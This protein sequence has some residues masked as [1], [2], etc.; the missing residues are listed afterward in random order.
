MLVLKLSKF[1]Y[2]CRVFNTYMERNLSNFRKSRMLLEKRFY[3][4]GILTSIRVPRLTKI[5]TLYRI[6]W[7]PWSNKRANYLIFIEKRDGVVKTFTVVHKM[8]CYLYIYDK[9]SFLSNFKLQRNLIFSSLFCQAKKFHSFPLK[10]KINKS[11]LE[12]LKMG[13]LISS[14]FVDILDSLYP[15]TFLEHL[16]WSIILSYNRSRIETKLTL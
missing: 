8:L 7:D 11:F 3:N 1:W 13:F 2:I 5:L 12:F 16:T 4:R 10:Y 9:I 15:P 6:G 14:K